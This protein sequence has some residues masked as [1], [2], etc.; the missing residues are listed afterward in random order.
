MFLSARCKDVVKSVTSYVFYDRIG[1]YPGKQEASHCRTGTRVVNIPD[2]GTGDA[3][4]ALAKRRSGL[5]HRR[6]HCV[7]FQFS[8]GRVRLQ[9]VAGV[10]RAPALPDV[11]T[12]KEA[13]LDYIAGGL[14]SV[15]TTGGKTPPDI[16]R[17]LNA[18]I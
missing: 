4:L 16:V 11:P 15:F 13:G 17:R 8:S 18:E 1:T 5:R 2:K 10:R 3:V 14:F 12:T 9:A 7:R 6:C